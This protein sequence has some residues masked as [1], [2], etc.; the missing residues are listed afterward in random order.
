MVFPIPQSSTRMVALVLTCSCESE[1]KQ[2]RSKP[3]ASD[4]HR[5]RRLPDLATSAHDSLTFSL[6]K[7]SKRVSPS[8]KRRIPCEAKGSRPHGGPAAWPRVQRG[9]AHRG[10]WRANPASG[11]RHA[12][13]PARSERAS[14]CCEHCAQR[15]RRWFRFSRC[16]FEPLARSCRDWPHCWNELVWRR[17]ALWR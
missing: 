1:D 4:V 13:S 7:L 10:R 15:C 2:V 12:L 6:A 8:S 14:R 5:I 9:L 16:N 17:T 3:A 11:V